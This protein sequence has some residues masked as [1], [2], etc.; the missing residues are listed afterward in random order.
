MNVLAQYYFMKELS[1]GL[2]FGMHVNQYMYIG[3]FQIYS[4]ILHDFSGSLWSMT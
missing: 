4:Q 2:I 1:G 3:Q